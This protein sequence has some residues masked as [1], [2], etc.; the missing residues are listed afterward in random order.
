MSAVFRE[1][2]CG[3]D[4]GPVYGFDTF[5]GLPEKWANAF[6]SG[7]F[8]LGGNLPPVHHNARLVKGLFSD[9]L[10]PWIEQQKVEHAGTMPPITYL[11]IDCD[12]Y[13]GARD[14]LT[15][16]SEYIAPGCLLIFDEVR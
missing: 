11:H 16:L 1:R 13:A 14:A 10:Q 5:T 4:A 2:Y 3:L 6:K 12:L 15:L 8:S 9:S 7:A